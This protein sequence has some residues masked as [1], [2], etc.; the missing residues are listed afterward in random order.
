LKENIIMFNKTNRSTKVFAV[1]LFITLLLPTIGF[2]Q[3]QSDLKSVSRSATQ[4]AI[5]LYQQIRNEENNLFFSPYS[6]YTIL[7]LMYGGADGETAEQM[8]TALHI[9]LEPE[10]F[11]SALVDIQGIL[12]K[13]KQNGGVDLS[14]ANSLW[15]QTGDSL[16]SEFL[17]LAENYLAEV[18]SVDYR[19]EPEAVR[20]EI[21]SWAE[22]KTEGRIKKIV[23]WD[24]H[25][26][27]HMLLANAIFFKGKWAS[28][29][30]EADTEM[31]PFHRTEN[32]TIEVPMMT[33]MGYFG[34]GQTNV[35][36]I[37]ELPY[38][39]DEL[40]MIIVLPWEQEDLNSV[41]EQMSLD[42]VVSWREELYEGPVEVYLP[43]FKI[44]SAFDMVRNG[45]LKALGIVRALDM[46]EAEFPG[47]GEYANWFSIQVFVHKA[48]VDV[49]EEGTEAAAVTVGGCFPSGTPV[50][51][52][53]GL[54][55]IEAIKAGAA[56]YVFDLSKGEW[57]TTQVAE[58]DAYQFS[59]EMITLQ[60]DGDTINATWN[61]PLFVVSGVDLEARRV[62][63]D[64][65]VDEDVSQV[66]GRWVEARDMRVGDVLMTRSGQSSTVIGTS[67]QHMAAEVYTLEIDNHHNYAVGQYGILVHNGKKGEGGTLSFVADHPFLFFIQDNLTDSIL[68]MG[69]VMNPGGE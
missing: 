14:I 13:V 46:A 51:T 32:D 26:E 23:D 63:M 42:D 4:F 11:H 45:D 49:N 9:Q 3:N 54:V 8:A 47:I 35:A 28:Q 25:P 50:L 68:F 27:T 2:G 44:T 66:H 31:M 30:D 17:E 39:G 62:P 15:P 6:I 21:N 19:K 55:A 12:N 24:L 37:L 67:S 5:D 36:E 61:H 60:V 59:G 22:E 20:D 41:E 18:L 38:E 34:Y 7:A 64:L 43:R 69:R 16:K 1:V 48:F 57:V 10:K 33:Q 29:F 52:P 40:S 53:D 58:R 56:I 65:P